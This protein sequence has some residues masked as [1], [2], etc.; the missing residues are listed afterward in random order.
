MIKPK[1]ISI[2]NQ[3]KEILKSTNFKELSNLINNSDT[4]GAAKIDIDLRG[5][6]W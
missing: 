5:S 3:L 1:L 2:S 4:W 6:S